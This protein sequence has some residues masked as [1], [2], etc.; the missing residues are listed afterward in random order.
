MVRI[1][2]RAV[3]STLCLSFAASRATSVLGDVRHG[4][5]LGFGRALKAA[6]ERGHDRLLHANTRTR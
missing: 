3:A 6:S 4:V 1:P 2:V 5:Q